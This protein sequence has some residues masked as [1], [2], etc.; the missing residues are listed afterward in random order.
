MHLL[1][2][3]CPSPIFRVQ[4]QTWR[5]VAHEFSSR[6]TLEPAFLQQLFCSV[7]ND[8]DRSQPLGWTDGY[9]H[10]PLHSALKA[11]HQGNVIAVYQYTATQ[12]YMV[13]PTRENISIRQPAV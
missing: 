6:C 3:G 5:R 13:K 2:H 7:E 9:A 8:N 4:L 1:S 10:V 11:R 12:Q